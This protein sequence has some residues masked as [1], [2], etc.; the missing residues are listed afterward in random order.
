MVVIRQSSRD[1]KG[2]MPFNQAL[3]VVDRGVILSLWVLPGARKTALD[4]YDNWRKSIRFKTEA[5]AQ[6]G[7]ANRSVLE[8]FASLL[9]K[10]T[11]LLKGAKSRQ[12][13][14]LVLGATL[15]EVRKA[16]NK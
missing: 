1:N 13:E 4:E 7:A 2:E 3:R 10:E 8:F 12:K 16:L 5:P 14:V 9:G 6:K 11:V 15:E